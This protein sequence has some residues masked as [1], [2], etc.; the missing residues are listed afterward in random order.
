MKDRDVAAA[1]VPDGDRW[2][3]M[4]SARVLEELDAVA[5]GLSMQEAERRVVRFGTNRVPAAARPSRPLAFLRQF[6]NALIYVL[7]EARDKVPA[8]APALGPRGLGAGG[9]PHR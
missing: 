9:D 8:H 3:A 2:H 1:A 5:A 6:N 7:I 4:P